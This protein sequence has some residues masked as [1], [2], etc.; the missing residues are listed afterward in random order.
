MAAAESTTSIG[1]KFTSSD[2]A[3]GEVAISLESTVGALKDA[4]R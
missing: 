2:K 3:A 4:I 1:V